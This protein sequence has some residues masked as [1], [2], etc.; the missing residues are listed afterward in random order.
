ME[1]IKILH[2]ADIHIGVA[3]SFLGKDAKTRQF[4]TLI[5]FERIVDLAVKENVKVIAIAGDT[6]NSNDVEPR[7]IEATLNKI[8]ANGDIKV[9]AIS[10]NHDP[11]NSESPFIRYDLP[12]NLYVLGVKDECIT[13]D[14]L[15]LNVYGRSFDS[16]YMKGEE[17]FT[18]APKDNGYV[19]LMLQHGELRSD[20]NSD[21]NAIT[22]K[23]VK[24]S[25]M[26]YIAL[27]HVHKRTEIG[28]I[29]KTHFAYC[30]CPEGQGFDELNEKGVYIGEIGK[31]YCS[32]TFTPVAKRSHIHEMIDVMGNSNSEEITART[33]AVLKEKYGENFAD[34]LY[35]IELIG[36]IP[37]DCEI[38]TAEI[39]T[40][41]N[42]TLYYVKVKD[43][44]DFAVDLSELA[45]ETSLK[46]IFVK[47]MLE[48]LENASAE[49]KEKYK[50]ALKL[51]LK[52][53]ISE[54]KYNED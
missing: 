21:Y 43:S 54:V 18:L 29:D 52:A 24:N 32:L 34:N 45:K 38:I 53:F 50:N 15:K 7:F 11:L 48:K 51:G 44:T 35:K 17:T 16:A 30:G 37:T 40:R 4:E 36:E 13:F 1:N 12:E 41:L 8:A 27:G 33:L 2:T 5:T 6:F 42:E 31:G 46:G 47:K 49:E 23:F 9:V 28:K 39:H 26:D 14:D 25:G 20:L 19:N 10:G 3:E 22:P